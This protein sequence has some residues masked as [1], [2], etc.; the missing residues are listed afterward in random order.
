MM[1]AGIIISS[2]KMLFSVNGV[3][4]P[5]NGLEL[6]K[7]KVELLMENSSSFGLILSLTLQVSQ[8]IITVI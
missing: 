6:A 7:R 3:H 8:I 1:T 5:I 2:R 4:Y